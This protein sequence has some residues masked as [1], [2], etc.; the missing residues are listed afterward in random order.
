MGVCPKP[1][2][3][4]YSIRLVTFPHVPITFLHV[5]PWFSKRFLSISYVP[6]RSMQTFH[7]LNKNCARIIRSYTFR[8]NTPAETG[9]SSSEVYVPIRSVSTVPQ[10][11]KKV[12]LKL[13]FLHVLDNPYHRI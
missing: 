10:K 13:T 2:V 1:F 5:P 12:D 7:D 11:F 8:V 9:K 6:I 3:I 4:K